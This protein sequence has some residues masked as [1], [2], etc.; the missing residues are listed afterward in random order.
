MASWQGIDFNERRIHGVHNGLVAIYLHGVI[1][2]SP[3]RG[4]RYK[5]ISPKEADGWLRR[6][7]ELYADLSVQNPPR[8]AK[9][10]Y[11]I[12]MKKLGKLIDDATAVREG[13]SPQ[14]MTQV[15]YA[16]LH[17][18]LGLPSRR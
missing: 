16:E 7:S 15:D 11:S 17:R 1:G 2:V 10:W 6:A 5:M 12:N 3:D 9:S 4:H 18:S 8:G 14:K 13:R